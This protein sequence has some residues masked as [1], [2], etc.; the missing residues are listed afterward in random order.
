MITGFGRTGDWFASSRVGLAPDLMTCAKGITSGYLPLG[1]VV[2]APSVW[3]PFFA[4]GAGMWRHGYTYSGHAAAAAAAMAN[5]DI[6]EREDLLAR[7][8]D[9]EAILVGG[10]RAARQARA[11][12]SE[13]R[14]GVGVL[15]AVQFERAAIDADA[16]LLA[17]GRPRVARSG[18]HVQDARQRRDP[19]LAPVGP[20][21]RRGRRAG[22]RD[23]DRP[24]RPG[25]ADDADRDPD[26]GQEPRV[27]GGGDARR[28]RRPGRAPATTSSSRR[29]RASARR[30]PTI[31]TSPP[32]RR[33]CPTPTPSSPPPT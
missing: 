26:R 25:V 8:I 22:E 4:E 31:S 32:G 9:L 18:D 23:R 11:S 30:S 27:P 21:R 5:L 16:T 17:T 6:M 29:A 2:A 1:A 19:G 3:E 33:S 20:H 10:A 24:G 12:S 14:S 7:A 13:V 15:A 28:R